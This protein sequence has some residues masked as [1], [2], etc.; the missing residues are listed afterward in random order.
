MDRQGGPYSGKKEERQD[1]IS[2]NNQRINWAKT[3][4]NFIVPVKLAIT[5]IFIAFARINIIS[6]GCIEL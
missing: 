6:T 3:N 2:G 1:S 4:Q 5:S